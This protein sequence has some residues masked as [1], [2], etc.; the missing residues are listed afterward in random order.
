MIL[1]RHFRHVRAAFA[2]SISITIYLL[3]IINYMSLLSKLYT[4]I[5]ATTLFVGGII[6]G[7]SSFYFFDKKFSNR[8]FYINAVTLMEQK[9]R[10]FKI[11]SGIVGFI[12]TIGAWV[13]VIY[14]FLAF[15]H[16][17]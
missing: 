8:N 17:V 1:A 12:L 9:G 15:A 13:A 14:S 11:F 10:S 2:F 6:L 16:K 3:A 4:R 5:N 7:L